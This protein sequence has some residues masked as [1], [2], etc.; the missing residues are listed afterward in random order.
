MGDKGLK[1]NYIGHWYWQ[2]Q[3][4]QIPVLNTDSGNVEYLWLKLMACFTV[5]TF[6]C[7]WIRF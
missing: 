7:G 1:I 2:H 6:I 3:G 5:I 4:K